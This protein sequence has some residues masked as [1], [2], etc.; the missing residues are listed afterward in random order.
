MGRCS[1]IAVAKHAAFT[2]I[3]LLVVIAIISI[4]A[5]LLLP[6][7]SMA[8]EKARSISCINNLKQIGTAMTMY[9]DDH[10][11]TLVPAEYDVNNGAPFRS[12]WPTI[13]YDAKYL[14]SE[15]APTIYNVK[16][17]NYVFHCPS[18]LPNVYRFNP[19]SRDD[20]EGAKAWPS[21]S[22]KTRH[23]FHIDCWY[24]IN[25]S[26]SRPEKWPFTRI[27]MD[28]SRS[29]AGNKFSAAARYPRM[30]VIFD[31]FW[32]HNGKDERINARHSKN[33][34]SNVLFFD[35]SAAAFD[36]FR[37]PTVH[38]SKVLN[39]IQWRFPHTD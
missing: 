37:I 33:T 14:P 16:L 38:S 26:T 8:K 28:G 25:G 3:E 7:L 15:T 12:G 20:P 23:A 27:P 4:L 11:G 30:P 5:A 1:S 34:R 18:G 39:G 22:E 24:G 36:T 17:G 35:N 21:P 10:S 13:L 31:G 19:T 6:A 32:I 29:S 9:S 2:L